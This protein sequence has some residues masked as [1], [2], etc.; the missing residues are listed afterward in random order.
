M[1]IIGQTEVEFNSSVHS[2]GR[3]SSFPGLSRIV[4]VAEKDVIRP[5]RGQLLSVATSGSGASGTLS[6]ITRA[7]APDDGEDYADK[8]K[9]GAAVHRQDLQ[10]RLFLC[11]GLPIPES[12]HPP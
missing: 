5:N 11:P 6:F 8:R 9:V 1:W 2:R 7:P 4:V 10:R 3:I 12:P